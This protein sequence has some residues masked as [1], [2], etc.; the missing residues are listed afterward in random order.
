MVRFC[1]RILVVH[2]SVFQVVLEPKLERFSGDLSGAGF[3]FINHD[4][5]CI[6]K[7]V[8][9]RFIDRG[10]TR[11]MPNYNNIFLTHYPN[12]CQSLCGIEGFMG[13][14]DT[15]KFKGHEI[16]RFSQKQGNPPKAKWRRL[17]FRLNPDWLEPSG[18]P[19]HVIFGLPF[20][21][22]GLLLFSP[23]LVLPPSPLFPGSLRIPHENILL[24]P[25]GK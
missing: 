21:L 3:S 9:I 18:A 11:L 17:F 19:G 16:Q 6:K 24:G 4:M 13:N 15:W 2:Q 1:R 8:E 25:D 12:P 14:P 23:Q 5:E 10:S 20:C 22:F 7:R